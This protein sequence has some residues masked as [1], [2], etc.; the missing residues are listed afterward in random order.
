MARPPGSRNRAEAARSPPAPEWHER[1]HPAG[2]HLYAWLQRVQPEQGGDQRKRVA[3]TFLTHTQ[4]ISASE[5]R[6]KILVV[7]GPVDE[8]AALAIIPAAVSNAVMDAL[9]PLR[10]DRADP[11]Y[12]PEKIWRPLQSGCPDQNSSTE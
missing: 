2:Q 10:I 7:A 1:P 6:A 5:V 4:S 3:P 11:P 9:A 12:T 8:E